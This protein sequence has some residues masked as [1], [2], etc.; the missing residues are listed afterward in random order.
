MT[1]PIPGFA[2]PASSLL[3]LLAVPVAMVFG[4][5]LLRRG[6]GERLRIFSLVVYVVGIVSLLALSGTYHLLP[7]GTTSR[8]VL[9]HLDFAAIWL[10]IAGTFT[11]VHIIAL[12][13]FWRWGMLGLIW[14]Y[15]VVGI[16][17]E[18][19]WLEEIP[20]WLA[21][22]FFLVLG[23][24]GAISA[25]RVAR[26]HGFAVVKDCI[27]GGIA[28]SVGATFEAVGH[29]TLIPG[30]FGPHELF[31]VA[32]LVGIA[33]HARFVWRFADE[34]TFGLALARAGV[35]STEHQPTRTTGGGVV[36]P[37]TNRAAAR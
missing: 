14:G 4:W 15:A 18:T 17:L 36:T 31:H 37:S 1:I 5:Y 8:L 6:H 33:Y 13:G 35:P 10:L 23:W 24:M 29:P 19:V 25:W 32:V 22:T 20:G 26:N 34:S 28:Y 30:V 9:R 27:Y 2:D 11:P 16:T 12:R 3:H 21:S 7:H